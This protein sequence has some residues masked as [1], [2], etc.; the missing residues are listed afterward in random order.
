MKSE[1]A[2]MLD[3]EVYN[4]MDEALLKDLNLCKDL[5]WEYN[6]I[7]PTN[8]KERNMKLHEILG[9]CDEDTFTNRFS[10]TTASMFVLGNISL[11]TSTSRCLTKPW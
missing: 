10:V 11:P 7:R 1:Y 6:Q 5:C 9:K 2:K 8:I 3:G 4:A